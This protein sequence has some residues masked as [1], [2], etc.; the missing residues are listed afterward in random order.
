VSTKSYKT[1]YEFDQNH[2]GIARAARAPS[3]RDRRG[4]R[5][6]RRAAAPTLDERLGIRARARLD[7]RAPRRDAPPRRV[8]ATRRPTG[9]T[10]R[11]RARVDL[12]T[13]AF[14]ASCARIRA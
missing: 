12:A 4:T 7:A 6:R 11:P 2:R 14:D 5:R 1:T 9:P 3:P 13:R 10:P 8:D